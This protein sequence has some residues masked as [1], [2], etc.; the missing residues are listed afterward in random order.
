MIFTN[1]NFHSKIYVFISKEKLRSYP[2]ILNDV[3]KKIYMQRMELQ[4][5]TE[6]KKESFKERD[7][8][9]VKTKLVDICDGTWENLFLAVNN[10]ET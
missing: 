7:L 6:L 4:H 2:K 5:L 10:L 9:L 1:S 3:E 8:S